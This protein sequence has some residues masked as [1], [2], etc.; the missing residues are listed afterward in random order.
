MRGIGI[1]VYFLS[2]L[3]IPKL[4]SKNI[5]NSLKK[6]I[7]NPFLTLEEEALLKEGRE[8]NYL[9]LSAIF[10]SPSNSYAIINRRIVKEK[11]VIDGKK[12]VKIIPG[13]VYL[14]DS[15]GKYILKLKY[16]A[17]D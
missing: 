15:K 4:Y 3:L 8:I 6:K 9:N 13:K 2:I 16:Y 14:E 11:D 5:Q 17:Q 10:Y 1:L 7:R 12:V